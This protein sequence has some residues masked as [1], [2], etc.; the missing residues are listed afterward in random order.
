MSYTHVFT[1]AVDSYRSK[2]LVTHLNCGMRNLYNSTQ[3]HT[4]LKT[5]TMSVYKE[6]RR[7]F[8]IYN[9]NNKSRSMTHN[10]LKN[11]GI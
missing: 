1:V 5:Y 11:K 2:H 6:K 10:D 4:K 9:Y 8:V 3:L 7:L